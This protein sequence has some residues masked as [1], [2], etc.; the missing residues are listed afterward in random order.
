MIHGIQHLTGQTLTGR[1]QTRSDN[2][3]IAVACPKR[4]VSPSKELTQCLSM[5]LSPRTAALAFA[6]LSIC[7]HRSDGAFIHVMASRFM[8]TIA[9]ALVTDTSVAWHCETDAISN[10][11]ISPARNRTCRPGKKSLR[12]TLYR[13]QNGGTNLLVDGPRRISQL[14]PERE[15][16]SSYSTSMAMRD[17]AQLQELTDKQGKLPSTV[18]VRTGSGGLH[19]YFRWPNGAELKNSAK[20]IASNLDT[21]VSGGYVIA[22]PSL[23]KCGKEDAFLPNS[24]QERSSLRRWP[25]GS[26]PL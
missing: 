5:Q 8:A 21:R 14:Q 7:I 17:S 9:N 26:S 4:N 16:A 22:P 19:Y 11:A 1:V 25:D 2:C 15:V 3:V 10:L 13:P 6:N 18:A 24:H 20:R 23:H 12:M